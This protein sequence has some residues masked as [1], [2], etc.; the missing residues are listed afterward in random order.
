MND[1]KAHWK[2][3]ALRAEA[4]LES[5]RSIRKL[6]H[7]QEL[8]MC[9]VEAAQATALREIQEILTDLRTTEPIAG[10]I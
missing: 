2:R 4:E 8:S 5:L 1:T 3:R 10:M 6:E 7:D 9:R